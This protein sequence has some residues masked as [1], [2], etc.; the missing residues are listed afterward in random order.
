LNDLHARYWVEFDRT[1]FKDKKLIDEI[2]NL[3]AEIHW[4]G[5]RVMPA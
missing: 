3:G 5:K 2:R 1:A 4:P